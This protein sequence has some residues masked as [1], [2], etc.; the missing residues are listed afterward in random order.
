MPIYLK[1]SVMAN[2]TTH[3]SV[4]MTV[5]VALASF[6]FGIKLYGF[7]TAILCVLFGTIGGL[8][9]DIDLESSKPAKKGFLFVSVFLATL[10]T[11]LYII[12]HKDINLLIP[13]LLLWL[14]VFGLL[15]FVVFEIFNRLTVHR[16]MVHSVPYMAMLSLMVVYGAYYGLGMSTLVSWF[17]ALFLFLGSLVHLLLDEIYS[18][19]LLNLRLKKS[20]G[21]A[22]KF[23][24]SSRPIGYA[25]LYMLIGVLWVFAP[26]YHDVWSVLS[27]AMIGFIN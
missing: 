13:S 23:F 3:L 18:V 2:F 5:S 11:L 21:T 20:S 17:L 22:F 9:P 16:G 6:G 14:V 4:A 19:N 15:R 7:G 24:E 27:A 26:D 1:E 10:T 25:V 12:H 8:L